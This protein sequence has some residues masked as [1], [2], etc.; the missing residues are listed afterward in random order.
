MAPEGSEG[1]LLVVVLRRRRRHPARR[2]R[3]SSAKLPGVTGCWVWPDGSPRGGIGASGGHTERCAT[4]TQPGWPSTRMLGLIDRLTN[5]GRSGCSIRWPFGK[6]RWMNWLPL[7]RPAHARNVHVTWRGSIPR[8]DGRAADA[9]RC[10]AAPGTVTDLHVRP[11]H[12][13]A[14]NVACMRGGRK[15]MSDTLRVWLVLA[16]TVAGA[17]AIVAGISEA[18]KQYSLAVLEER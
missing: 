9:R 16:L 2:R 6:A 13:F 1:S 4:G 12:F 10:R 14:E 5:A 15:R 18:T 17:I 8:S 3:M 11:E 7:R